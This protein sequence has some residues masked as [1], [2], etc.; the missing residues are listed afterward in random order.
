MVGETLVSSMKTSRFGSSLGCC[1]CKVLRAAATSGRSCS[2]ARRLFFKAQLQM[3]QESG[4]RRLTDRHLFLRQNALK[5]SQRDIRLLRHQLPYQ[6]LVRCQSI[7]LAPPELGRTDATRFAVQPTEAHDRADTHAKLL[8]SFRNGGTILRRPNYASTQIV[9]IWLSHPMLASVP[10]GF[11]NLIRRR[12]GI[13]P[14]SVFSGN[15]LGTI[16]ALLLRSIGAVGICIVRGR[17][18]LRRAF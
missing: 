1:F 7:S 15:A 8:R 16:V 5:S 18:P 10:V 17:T 3:M 9:R 13:H 6:S 12:R 4:D 11:L 2:A 14:D